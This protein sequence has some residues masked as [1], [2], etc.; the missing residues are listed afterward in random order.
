MQWNSRKGGKRGQI[1]I[2]ECRRIDR[3]GQK[4]P[5]LLGIQNQLQFGYNLQKMA[6]LDLRGKE[7]S[8]ATH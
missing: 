7:A 8:P 3:G 1:F 2:L 5:G 4:A 6:S